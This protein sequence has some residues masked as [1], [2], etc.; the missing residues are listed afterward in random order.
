[1]RGAVGG[2]PP[3][4]AGRQGAGRALLAWLADERAPGVCWV[5]GAQGSG[6]SHL[7]C[8][9][10]SAAGGPGAPGTVRPA[11]AVSLAGLGLE[12]AVAVLARRLGVGART[13]DQLLEALSERSAPQLLVLWDLNRAVDPGRIVTAL[14]GARSPVRGLRIV[15]EAAPG[16]AVPAGAAVLELDD[17]Q[18]TDAARFE[19]WYRSLA[20]G[21]PFGAEQVYP[22]PGLARLA[23]LVPP[24]AGCGTGVAAAWWAALPAEVRPAVS[25]L[26]RVGRP[27]SRAQWSALAGAAAVE[28]A[29]ALVPSHTAVGGSWSVPAGWVGEDGG[30]PAED[31]AVGPALGAELGTG[32]GVGIASALHAA[33]TAGTLPPAEEAGLLGLLVLDA[34]RGGTEAPW[35]AQPSVLTWADPRAVTAALAA[36]PAEP[37]AAAWRRA[38]PALI[39]EPDAAVR[40]EVLRTHLLG[41][42]PPV[43][44]PAPGGVGWRARWAH[45]TSPEP[46]E[47]PGEP[48]PAGELA[49]AALGRGPYAR[50][51][52][53]A[54][55]RG[56]VRLFDPPRVRRHRPR[57][58]ICPSD[59]ARWRAGR[60]APSPRWTRRERRGRCS[61]RSR[62]AG[63]GSR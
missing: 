30:L 57:G 59:C 31:R 43:E 33:V 55:E 45:W 40:A 3:L 63:T 8:W 37:P 15:L 28:R 46:A 58:R 6:K 27:L 47:A 21:S 49:V 62:N 34:V 1:M 56:R 19:R 23:A 12:G 7:L 29:A 32:L 48:L 44:H 52:V 24:E 50:W 51:V 20:A 42:A 18:W 39:E 14:L 22:N 5:S 26:A 35:S 4:R 13:V 11:A 41:T 17:P 16:C 54:D 25:A 38:L 9:L 53:V 36:R 60:T 2:L 10:A 61:A